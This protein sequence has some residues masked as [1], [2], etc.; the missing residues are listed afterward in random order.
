[1]P[2]ATLD[3]IPRGIAVRYAARD[4]DATLR[5]Y[6]ILSQMIDQM[7]LREVYEIDMGI[8]P[9][10]DRMR[11]VGMKVDIP[12]F[13][14][15]E[16][17][18]SHEMN[19]IQL[20]IT[21]RTGFSINPVSGDQTAMMLV[22]LKVPMTKMTKGGSRESTNDKVLESLRHYH[23]AVGLVCDYRELAKLRDS[24]C[25]V[26]PRLVDSDG[27]IR[28]NFRITR[29]SSGRLSAT[30]PNLLAIPVRSEVAKK[31]REGFV[32]EKGCVLGSWDLDQIEMRIMAD[33]SG[34]ANLCDG[35]I[36]GVDVHKKTGG[37]I[38]GKRPEDVTPMERYAAKRV[39]FGVITGI[40]AVGLLDQMA[41]A[42]AKD[43]T[44]Y[45]C[46]EAIDEYFK[47][48]PGVGSYIERRR[49]EARR[50]GYVRDR[51]GRI[52][53]LPGA[54]SD[55]PRI[56]E[57]AN[58]QSH[59]HCIQAGAQGLIKRAMKVLWT[60]WREFGFAGKIEPLLQ[61]HD[62]LLFEVKDHP[63]WRK[64]WDEL[65][66]ERLTTTTK[67]RV[68]VKAKGSYGANWGVLKD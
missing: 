57:E 21:E 60:D 35:F 13:H 2:E 44:E 36:K 4:A 26:L 20:N 42:G 59:S 38:Y 61:I 56:R 22:A 34:D 27:R 66:I 25:V 49:A 8:I 24:F 31:I 65:V 7:G 6:P 3:D 16:K 5:I 17:F 51:W 29:V 43:W 15:L 23:P 63:D 12:H 11:T 62:E 40:T 54:L 68:P 47:I 33:E 18:L 58:R 41:L 52:R 55:I 9:M 53:Y 1:M 14:K 39:G 46:Q 32:A 67:L 19:R 48:Y 30:N 64:D 50:F 28:C 10:V 45:R 37:L